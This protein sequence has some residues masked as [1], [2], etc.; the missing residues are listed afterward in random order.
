V[1]KH[2]DT[3]FVTHVPPGIP[4]IGTVPQDDSHV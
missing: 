3:E 1:H 2:G 4:G